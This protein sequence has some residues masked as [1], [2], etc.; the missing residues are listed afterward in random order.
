MIDRHNAKTC[1]IGEKNF[2]VCC[3]FAHK[4]TFAGKFMKHLFGRN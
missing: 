4:I 1:A 2:G 3:K